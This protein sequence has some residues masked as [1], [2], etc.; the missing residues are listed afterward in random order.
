M[1]LLPVQRVH[2]ERKWLLGRENKRA[3]AHGVSGF[4]INGELY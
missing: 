4:L 2:R 1:E 3:I